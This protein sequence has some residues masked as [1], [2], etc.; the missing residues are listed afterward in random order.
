MTLLYRCLTTKMVDNVK[1]RELLTNS[2]A[3]VQ[4]LENLTST[5]KSL[6]FNLD[7]CYLDT[8][9]EYQPNLQTKASWQTIVRRVSPNMLLEEVNIT[10]VPHPENRAILEE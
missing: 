1:L 4:I 7:F 5:M 9:D 2:M 6:N 3:S 8:S 10:R